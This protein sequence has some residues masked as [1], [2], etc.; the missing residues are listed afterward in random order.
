MANP[1]QLWDHDVIANVLL[2]CVILH[3]IVIE[4]EE[5]MVLELGIELPNKIQMKKD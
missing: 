4:G 2:A 3:N 5:D 1:C